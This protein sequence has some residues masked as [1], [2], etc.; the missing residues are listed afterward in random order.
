LT[1]TTICST[2]Q[3]SADNVFDLNDLITSGPTTGTWSDD[4]AS[5]ALVGS[6]VTATTAMEGGTYSF[7]YT[8]TGATPDSTDA[9]DNQSYTIQLAVENCTSVCPPRRCIPMTITKRN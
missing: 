5:G 4:D 2:D 9:C 7:T 3:G 8:I 1:D 6:T